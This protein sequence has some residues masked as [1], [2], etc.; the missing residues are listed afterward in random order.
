MEA[1]HQ[2]SLGS[3]TVESNHFPSHTEDDEDILEKETIGKGQ[4]MSKVSLH[5]RQ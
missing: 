4:Q 3:I 2:E 1:L 5:R